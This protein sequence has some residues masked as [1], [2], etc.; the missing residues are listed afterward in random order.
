MPASPVPENPV[1]VGVNGT[2]AGLAAVRLG[3]REAVSRDRPLRVVHALTPETSGHET[4][5]HET[6]GYEQARRLLDEA[7]STA[8]RSTPRVRV[9]GQIVD[10][11][12]ERVLLRLSRTA[13]LL[14]MGDDD[15][16]AAPWLPVTSVLVQLAGRAFCPVMVAR[17]PRPTAGPVLAAVD[18][19]TWSLLALRHAVAEA[20][21]LDSALDVAYVQERSEK[22]ARDLLAEATTAAGESARPRLLT[23]EPGPALVRASGHARMIIAG[24]RGTHGAR[25]LGSVAK[26]ILHRSG[27][28]T[29]FVHGKVPHQRI[30]ANQTKTL[31]ITAR[32]PN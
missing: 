15:L 22:E 9:T 27:C 1:V 8:Q 7:V 3:A 19:S 30:A 14:V 13:E 4:G 11:R 21:R 20:R 25:V 18:G 32:V 17:G 26:Q 6:G 28:P 5:G 2:A 29:V 31:N 23:G 10:G 16:G 24:P 12:P